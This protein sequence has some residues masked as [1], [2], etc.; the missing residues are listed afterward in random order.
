MSAK[1]EKVRYYYEHGLWTVENGRLGAAVE[2][3]WIT[4]EEYEEIC[5]E[6]YGNG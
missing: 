6:A 4:A 3:G 1:Y 5:G 2:K